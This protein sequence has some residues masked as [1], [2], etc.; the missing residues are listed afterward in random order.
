[1][2]FVQ[3]ASN[4]VCEKG[5]SGQVL[6]WPVVKIATELDLVLLILINHS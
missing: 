2:L 4:D 3:V 1:M 5:D 6:T